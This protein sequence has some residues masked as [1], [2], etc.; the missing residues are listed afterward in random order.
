L[1]YADL[2]N[3]LH[4]KERTVRDLVSYIKIR[5]SNVTP[6]YNLLLGAGASKSSGI[7]TG[8]ELVDQWREELYLRVTGDSEY[9]ESKAK[10][11]FLKEGGAWYSSSNEYSALFEKKF[12]LPSQR[13]RFVEQEVDNKI[14]SIGYSYLV[15]LTNSTNRFFDTI[16]T[17][18]FDDLINDSFYQFSQV[19]PVVC[20]HDSSVNS[21]SIS[22]TRPKIIKL[23]GD[24]LFDDIKSTLRETETLETNIKNKLIEFSKEFGLI[25]VG[26]AGNDRSIMDVINYLLKTDDYLKN[27]IYWCLRNDDYINPDLRKLLW[28]DKV[29]FVNIDGFDEFMAEL[30]HGLKGELSLKDNFTDTKKS[31]IIESF[32][33]DQFKLCDSSQIIKQDIE[34]LK[35]HKEDEDISKFIRELA[36]DRDDNNDKTSFQESDFKNLLNLDSLMKNNKYLAA[37]DKAEKYISSCSDNELKSKYIKKLIKINVELKQNR[38]AIELSDD[39]INLDK[40]NADYVL[41]KALVIKDITERCN[42]IS[43]VATDFEDIY[44]FNNFYVRCALKELESTKQKPILS[45][46]TML[47]LLDQ[48]L[49]LE[50]S[51]SNPAWEIKLDVLEKKYESLTDKKSLSDKDELVKNILTNIKKV[52]PNH[53]VN[54]KVKNHSFINT[55]KYE[56]TI[57]H[58]KDMKRVFKVSPQKKKDKLFNMICDSYADFF[59][60]DDKGDY[61]KDI[62]KFLESDFVKQYTEF[63][64]VAAYNILKAKYYLNIERDIN[65]HLEL[66]EKAT[67]SKNSNDYS[68]Y[69]VDSFCQIGK[70]I[71]RAETYINGIEDDISKISFYSLLSDISLEDS[72][73]DLALKHIEEAYDEGLDLESYISKKSFILLCAKNYSQTISLIDINLEYINSNT[74]KDILRINRELAKKMNGNKIDKQLVTNIISRKLSKDLVLCA[75][76]ILDREVAVKRLIKISISEKYSNLYKLKS[77]PAIPD[78]YLNE[79]FDN[80]NNISTENNSVVNLIN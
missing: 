41:D 16:Y 57:E 32:T 76:A 80:L 60:Y 11:Y 52:N 55:K 54:F 14:P 69:I 62:S 24:Y 53:I 33:E 23:H 47:E 77:W 38:E 30:H 46:D 43:S 61:Q 21:I 40:F 3:E 50:P 31:A 10:N 44:F 6:N 42:Y 8:A 15:S 29:Y 74:T 72:K 56:D 75:E 27:G 19:R 79:Y 12:D 22:S 78:K 49:K 13:R 63:K 36:G 28:K 5:T 71:P 37:K 17:T 2:K 39:L 66:I 34:N 25:V 51:I 48:S 45:L 70:N 68:N 67:Q 18:N 59:S 20:A 73:Y 4:H 26:Y 64:S 9:E 35:K 65:K 7:N 1:K 58:I